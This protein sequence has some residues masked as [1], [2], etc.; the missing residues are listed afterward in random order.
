MNSW[1]S[2]LNTQAPA[3]LMILCVTTGILIAGLAVQHAV[4]RSP[5]ARHAVLL[6]TLIAVG[7][8]PS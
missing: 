1:L 5:A 3:A 2:G 8:V 7:S 6:W 4:R